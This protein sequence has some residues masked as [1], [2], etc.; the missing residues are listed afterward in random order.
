MK[1]IIQRKVS[2]QSDET[3]TEPTENTDNKIKNYGQHSRAIVA[4]IIPI[5]GH[6]RDIQH[7]ECKY[8]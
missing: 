8:G 1:T 6:G 5:W 4:C 7:L 2:N 3:E